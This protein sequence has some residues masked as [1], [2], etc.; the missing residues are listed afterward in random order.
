[1]IEMNKIYK[2]I[3]RDSG[4]SIKCSEKYLIPW[5]AR[6]FEVESFILEEPFQEGRS[7]LQINSRIARKNAEG[8]P[9]LSSNQ[10]EFCFNSEAHEQESVNEA[11]EFYRKKS[12]SG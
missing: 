10:Y 4:A 8:F 2:M 12:Y 5:V 7:K 1:M 3:N 6:G 9:L 11:M